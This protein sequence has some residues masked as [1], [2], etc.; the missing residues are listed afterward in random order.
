MFY[1]TSQQNRSSVVNI[2]NVSC[3]SSGENCFSSAVLC[4]SLYFQ[5]CS[6]L[7]VTNPSEVGRQNLQSA[8]TICGT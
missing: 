3:A 4:F 1:A 6:K 8:C 7:L 5:F 2:Y